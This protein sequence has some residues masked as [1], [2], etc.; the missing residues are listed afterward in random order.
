METIRISEKKDQIKWDYDAEAD[1]LYI[2]FDQP[3]EAEGIDLGNGT[4]ARVNVK[5]NEIAGFTIINPVQKTLKQLKG[6]G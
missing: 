1:V 5:T 2:Y 3:T 6:K 4:I